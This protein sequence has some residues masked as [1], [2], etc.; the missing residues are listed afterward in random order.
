MCIGLPVKR[1]L[2]SSDYNVNVFDSFS[3]ISQIPD[4]MKIC[5]VGS[6]LFHADGHSGRRTDRYDETNSHFSKFCERS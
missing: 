4:F 6:E 1:L 3:K 2:F 5:P